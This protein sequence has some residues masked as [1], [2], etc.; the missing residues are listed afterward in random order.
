MINP[1][2][3]YRKIIQQLTTVERAGLVT[4]MDGTISHVVSSPD[5]AEVTPI[6]RTL[7]G[8]L[9]KSLTL[10]AVV[11]GRAA[12][13]LHQRVGLE[14]L[15]YVGNHGLEQWINGELVVTPEASSARQGL[16][17][18]MESI[19]P[20]LLPGMLLEDKRV[21]LSIHYRQAENP[22]AAGAEFAPILREAV[23]AQNLKL[24]AGKRVFEVRPQ[25]EIDKGSAFRR[26]V[27]DYQLEA[28]IYMGDDT[29]DA[30]A[31][32]MAQTLRAEGIC[33]AFGVGV[34]SEETPDT[35]QES[36]DVMVQGVSGV[37]SLLASISSALIAS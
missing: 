12:D 26:L 14:D 32:R 34:T 30:D 27:T 24:F 7:L 5:Q 33:Q 28:A 19:R 10:V 17:A 13:D 21:T 35:V 3:R 16:E 36:A 15:V 18:V 6:S 29:T 2:E 9:Q 22:D 25:L 8:R 23:E 1:N 11:S 4:D 31:L 37:E 20:R